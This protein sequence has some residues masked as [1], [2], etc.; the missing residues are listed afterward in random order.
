MPQTGLGLLTAVVSMDESTA[1]HVIRR[2]EFVQSRLEGTWSD[3][4][5][6]CRLIPQKEQTFLENPSLGGDDDPISILA[7]RAGQVV[8]R[9]DLIP[10]CLGVNGQKEP[11]LWC[12][13]LYVPA[14]VRNSLAGAMLVLKSQ[15][16]HST[17]GV[18]GVSQAAL[19][20]YQKLKW[21]QVAMH[22]YILLRRSRA[23]VEHY[24][25]NPA[26]RWG[27]RTVTDALLLA[28]RAASVLARL[29]RTSGLRIRQ[30]DRAGD[31][32]QSLLAPIPQGVETLR[33]A[34]ILNWMLSHGFESDARNRK[35]LFCVYNRAGRLAG[36][37][38]A[39]SRFYE[40]ATHR[41]FKNLQLG[42]LQDWRIFDPAALSLRRL[43]LLAVRE[44]SAWNPD[45]IELCVP[46]SCP[47]M[48][49]RR[50]GFWPAGVLSF[51][52]KRSPQSPLS[53]AG[54]PPPRQW[55]VTPC[56]GDNLFS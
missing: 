37:F 47:P 53:R 17:V 3:S 50:W 7:V 21:E 56:D 2:R 36:Y 55:N 8:G 43:M 24:L 34:A 5:Q 31:E 9:M 52:G 25:G 26:I 15:Q 38:L 28:H 16:L 51:L 39:K 6:I 49:W 27:A 54:L 45:A 32:F 12:S 11:I 23:V 29:M 20:I 1:Y 4:L 42:S 35:G 41:G 44:I 19:P 10:G 18:V 13:N 22:R 14:A 33:S 48:P 46:E 40:S 30:I